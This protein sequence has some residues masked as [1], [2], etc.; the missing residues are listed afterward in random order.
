MLHNLLSTILTEVM[1]KEPRT[2]GIT[3]WFLGL[4]IVGFQLC[5][6]RPWTWF[7]MAP[8][9]ICSGF[10]IVLELNDPYVGPAILHEAGRAY[11]FITYA[12]IFAAMVLP[13]IGALRGKRSSET[14]SAL[15]I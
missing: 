5:K 3:A 10:V 9:V 1:D 8:I 7:L 2:W 14:K 13:S 12:A 15:R 4:G 6:K 11:F